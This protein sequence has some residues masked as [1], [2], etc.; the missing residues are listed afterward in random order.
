MSKKSLIRISIAIVIAV[1]IAVVLIFDLQ[2]YLTLEYVKGQQQIFIEFY[3]SYTILAIATYFL[4]YVFVAALSIPGAAVMT[5]IGGALF[6]LVVGTVVISFA[7]TI[8]AS[9]A[10]IASRFFFKDY[11]QNKFGDK[12]EI[13]NQGIKKEGGY[14]LFTL[15]LVPLFPFFLINL[16]MGLT[17]IRLVTF[18][19]VSQVGMLP[20]TIVFVFAGTQ[21]AQVNSMKSILSPGIIIAFTIL[22]FFPLVSKKSLA[23]FNKKRAANKV[24][25]DST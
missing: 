7:S 17:P 4:T 11:I 22:G 5:L 20:G 2:H 24:L 19:L 21:L 18:F 8:G 25:Q 10:F 23:F 9:L 13:I 15:R 1:L 3:Q 6:G 12:L 14:Y 16:L